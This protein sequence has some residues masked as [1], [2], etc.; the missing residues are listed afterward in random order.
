MFKLY[1]YYRSSAA[2]RVRIALGL[3]N[4]DYTTVPVH[5]LKNGGE[6]HDKSYGDINPQQLIPLLVHN[7][8][9]I[10]QSLAIIEYLEEQFPLPALLPQ[11]ALARATVRS[12]AYNIACDT[13]PLNNLRVLKYLQEDLAINDNQKQAWYSHWVNTTFT[14]LEK[15]LTDIGSGGNYCVDDKPSLADVVLIPQVYNAERFAISL[16]PFPLIQSIYRYCL[17]QPAFQQAAPDKQIDAE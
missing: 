13:H 12:I 15:Q 11:D 7:S 1:S 10:Q 14:G 4:L 5:L 8:K 2:Y 9:Y 16:E 6:Q 17:Q 3:K